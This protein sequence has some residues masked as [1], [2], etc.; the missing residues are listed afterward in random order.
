MSK[1]KRFSWQINPIHKRITY[2]DSYNRSSFIK[3]KATN[4]FGNTKREPFPPKKN[5]SPA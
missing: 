2:I 3:Q 5:P 4:S 1:E